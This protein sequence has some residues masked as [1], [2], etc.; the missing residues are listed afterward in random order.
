L[1]DNATVERFVPFKPLMPLVDVYL[2]NGGFGGV[3]YA[4]ANGVPIV[5]AGASEDKAE[6]GNRVAFT[7]AGINLRTSSPTPQAIAEA[8][9]T[10]LNADSYRQRASALQAEIATHDAAGEAAEL[11]ERLAK[12]QAPILRT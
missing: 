11:L 10:I 1:P 9:R 5:A 7:G 4:L 3:Q 8:V 2:T 12:R 6:I